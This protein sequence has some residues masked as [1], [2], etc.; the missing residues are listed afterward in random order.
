M[1]S[2]A[3]RR[4]PRAWLRIVV[5]A[6]LAV[7][8]L[9]AAIVQLRR[10]I[11]VDVVELPDLVG[12][13]YEDAL[14]Q[15]HDFGLVAE[16]YPDNS[17]SFPAQVVTAQAPSPGSMVRS[18][19]N[20]SVGVNQPTEVQ[21]PTLV[22]L[23]LNE[24][25]AIL[26]E[27]GLVI[28]TV[29]YENSDHP[30]G[31]VT[32]QEPQ[33]GVVLSGQSGLS[34]T[35][36][37]GAGDPVAELPDVVGLRI[38][39]A[40]RRLQDAGFR[41]IQPVATGISFDDYEVVEQQSPDP[42]SEVAVTM[43]V[44]LN[45]RLSAREVVEVPDVWGHNATTAGML[46][47]AAGLQVGEV[48]YMEDPEQPR[49]VVLE[50]L[51]NGYTL[52]DTPVS[53]L[54]N[55]RDGTYDSLRSREDDDFLAEDD[56]SF[57]SGDDGNAGDW[58]SRRT[59]TQDR[60]QDRIQPQEE[61]VEELPEGARRISVTF[62]PTNLGVRALLE[63]EYDLR[64]VVQDEQGERTVVDQRVEAGGVVRDDV[65]VYGDALLQTY[66]N[67]VFFQAWRP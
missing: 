26:R 27:A 36:S 18:G 53:L 34:V 5:V 62:D 67:G 48:R 16:P 12:L 49:G 4:P 9:V 30:V 61:P 29:T 37:R 31:T 15:L 59:R 51:P 35:V 19:R 41:S 6:L 25:T 32:L 11:E 45:Y 43:P 44:Q 57:P 46:L 21:A 39:E 13:P 56:R 54:V 63:D 33:A 47:R 60:A 22:G 52:V 42:E 2:E 24:A 50:V 1:V 66:I 20:I 65:I 64:L 3:P 38:D 14:E 8:I 58:L 23:Q 28:D 17:R 10:Y 55:A 40:R 7:I